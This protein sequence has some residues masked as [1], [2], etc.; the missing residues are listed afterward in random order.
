MLSQILGTSTVTDETPCDPER[1]LSPSD[2]DPEPISNVKPPDGAPGSGECTPSDDE[3]E[4]QKLNT[5]D[6]E[7]IEQE[8]LLEG[9]ARSYYR[10]LFSSC[11]EDVACTGT[12]TSGERELIPLE[13]LLKK[14]SDGFTY[15]NVEYPMVDVEIEDVREEI[16]SSD[17]YSDENCPGITCN[18]SRFINMMELLVG[19][20]VMNDE[21][22]D[23]EGQGSTLIHVV[24]NNDEPVSFHATERD[25]INAMWE[26]ARR[27][28]KRNL[29]S[30]TCCH[31][32][33]GTD[34]T[35]LGI[36]ARGR[37]SWLPIYRDIH[38]FYVTSVR[39]YLD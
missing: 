36:Q 31:I 23:F 8:N 12:D 2:S 1:V 21:E 28:L 24:M 7:S 34:P 29:C 15:A 37:F 32:K 38:T 11:K 20:D 30:D 9:N 4:Y 22:S 13:L 25:A 18:L 26:W 3:N 35:Q 16:V 6:K 14:L 39:G 27:E 10:D 19:S 5:D 33:V 17:F